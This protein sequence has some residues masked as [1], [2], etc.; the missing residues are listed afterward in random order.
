MKKLIFIMLFC[1]IFSFSVSAAET[2]IYEEQYE[3]SGAEEINDFLDDGTRNFLEINGIDPKNPDWVNS[4]KNENII[5]HIIDFIKSGAKAPARAAAA[6]IGIILISAAVTAF[7]EQTGRFEPALFAATL[8]VGGV[9][10]ADIWGV[11]SSAAEALKGTS[12]FM[13]SFVPVFVGVV[14]MSGGAITS[15]AMGG[16]LIGGAEAVSSLA[17]FFVLPAMGGYL[18]IS[19][20]STVSPLLNNSNIA[21]AIKKVTLWTL[22]FATTLFLGILSIQ[23]AVNSSAD[24]MSVRTAR[25][26]LG[27]S[28]PIAGN[29]L[30]EAFTTV[31]ASVSLLRS[32][33]G[34][35]GVV[36]LAVM[37]L[38]V[39][40]ELVL[41]RIT[42]LLTGTVSTAFSL[43]KISGLL[44]AVD[45]M[46]SLL[47]ATVLLVAGMFIISLTV[48]ISAGKML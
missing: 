30:A 47:L 13:L 25:F 22:S 32:S 19:I 27:T 6:I 34:I 18:S 2:D 12:Y 42:L 1:F 37:F 28:V 26:I 16:L 36:A 23:T 21:A 33:V 45:D 41:W 3:I 14:S 9:I 4:I 44:K 38:P 40:I 17:S 43:P 7:G 10:A 31:T 46:I 20:C 35:Y 15:A 5:S 48:V 24:S 29:T 11:V 39:I 8:A